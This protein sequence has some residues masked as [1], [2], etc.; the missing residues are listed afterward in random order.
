[1]NYKTTVG[2]LLLLVLVGGYFLFYERHREPAPKL[3]RSEGPGRPLFV[4]TEFSIE[5]VKS[6]TI[7][8]ADGESFAATAQG[9]D[10]W[11]TQPVRVQ[12]NSWSGRGV[13][14]E[15]AKLRYSQ[16]LSPEKEGKTLD[17]Y[18][19]AEPR[20]TVTIHFESDDNLPEWHTVK[21]GKQLGGSA[22]VM[23]N[24]EPDVYIVGDALHDRVFDKDYAEWR[25]KS[26]D[27]PDEGALTSVTLEHDDKTISLAKADS[28]WVLSAPNA[29]RA[30]REKVKSLVSDVGGVYI[31]KFVKD[32][33]DNL[34]LYGLDRPDTVVTLVTAAADPGESATS[35]PADGKAASGDDAQKGATYVLRIGAPADVDKDNYY[36]TMSKN[37]QGQDIV[38]TISKSAVKKFEKKADEFRDKRITPIKAANVNELTIQTSTHGTL[39]IAKSADGWAFDAQHDPGF[40]ADHGQAA[41][42][43]RDIV[44]VEADGFIADTAPQGD[45]DA[46]VTLSAIARAQPDVVRL[47]GHDDKHYLVLR[48]NE[49]V[50]YLAKRDDVSRVFEPALACRDRDVV[51]LEQD[52]LQMLTITQPGAGTFKFERAFEEVTVKADS[53]GDAPKSQPAAQGESESDEE[54]AQPET[55]LVPGPWRLLGHDAFETDALN[56]LVRAIT[57]IRADGWIDAKRPD[58]QTAHKLVIAIR[59]GEPITLLVDFESNGTTVTGIDVPFKATSSLISAIDAEMRDRAVLS[60]D[61]DDVKSITITHDGQAITIVKDDSDYTTETD[62]ELDDDA[63]GKIF[64]TLVGLRVQRYPGIDKPD[65]TQVTIAVDL[66]DDKSHTVVIPAT[67][68]PDHIVIV[69]DRV[70]ELNKDDLDK[71]T[72]SVVKSD[73]DDDGDDG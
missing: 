43:V 22:Y 64:D 7:E 48:N 25:K 61:G 26:I 44:D 62:V 17:D 72:A 63:C 15:A 4:D 36:A 5:A 73:D 16:K 6:Y 2:L 9:T 70:C 57:P 38:F 51:T 32:Q 33:P 1:M 34:L 8:R 29:G 42:L 24:D 41:D 54:M 53:A 45:P 21:L 12:L 40:A 68:D 37:R 58:D 55:K 27:V 14:E 20:A 71:L 18:G 31:N 59:N 23:R 66:G 60:F 46:T 30:D 11:Q 67:D 69:D 52:T 3:G 47:F 13:A 39:K 50:G 10:W 35:Q 56:S 19:L 65:G 28:A 49:T